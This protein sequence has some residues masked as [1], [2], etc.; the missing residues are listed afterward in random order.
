MVPRPTS[1][2]RRPPSVPRFFR[3]REIVKNP[4]RLHS[5]LHEYGDFVL[6][7]GLSDLYLINHPDF[8]R[9]VL[10]DGSDHVSKR[11]VDYRVL[12]QFMGDGLLSTNGPL[13]KRQRQF[14]QPFFARHNLQRFD[15]TINTITST[16]VEAWRQSPEREPFCVNLEMR[17]L[18]LRIAGLTMFGLSIDQH[19]DEINKLVDVFNVPPR[20]FA[21]R[22][23]LYPWIPTP[24]NLKRSLA[25]KR[26]DRIIYGLI[27]ERHRMGSEGE[28]ILCRFISAEHTHGSGVTGKQVRDELVTF[29]F[30]GVATTACALT[31]A[32][33]L[34]A[35][36]PDV[37]ARLVEKL[38]ARLNGAAATAEDLARIP[39]LG[40]VV[41]EALRLYPPVWG[42]ARRV[43]REYTFNGYV[44]PAKASV[45]IMPYSLHRHP[46]FWS[47]PECFDPG[48]FHPSR[49]K[50]RHF[51]AYLPFA[52]GERSCIGAGMAMLQIQLVLAQI[53]QHFKLHAVPDHP[54]EP[55]GRVTL[56]PR[57]GLPMTLTRR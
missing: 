55:M 43:E 35:T 5:L 30:S 42:F 11:T 8:V 51:F 17:R 1:K 27:D 9:P 41:L 6:W 16:M 37:E 12:S 34:I 25:R 14:M 24:N 49:S 48:R 56:E 3:L 46:E 50:D 26:L 54:V 33:H 45:G 2:T 23:S 28:D 18:T 52:A 47:D 31:W 13:W 7:H 10:L 32:L 44:L 40:C 36:H 29:L 21:P 4:L 15:E 20:A 57:G 19:V 39:Y 53:L 22:M 38:D